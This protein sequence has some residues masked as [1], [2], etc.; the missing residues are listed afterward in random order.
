LKHFQGQP[1][2]PHPRVQ[3]KSDKEESIFLLTPGHSN[4]DKPITVC[5]S[6]SFSCSLALPDKVGVGLQLAAGSFKEG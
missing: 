2:L 1:P 3:S 5:M 6:G 4:E